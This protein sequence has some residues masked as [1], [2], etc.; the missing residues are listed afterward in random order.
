MTVSTRT[1][2]RETGCIDMSTIFGT[3]QG[4]LTGVGHVLWYVDWHCGG[5]TTRSR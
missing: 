5:Q 1:A 3:V 4:V 2:Y